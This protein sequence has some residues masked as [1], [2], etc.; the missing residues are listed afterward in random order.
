M[1]AAGHAVIAFDV[2][3][4]PGVARWVETDLSDPSSI[5]AALADVEGPV[6]ALINTAGVPPRAPGCRQKSRM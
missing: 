4:V 5:A 2:A 3:E 1:A 6:D